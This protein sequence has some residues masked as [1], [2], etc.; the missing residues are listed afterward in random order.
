MD[1]R[2]KRGRHQVY[3]NIGG[4]YS[5][6][7]APAASVGAVDCST[8][9]KDFQRTGEGWYGHTDFV[10]RQPVPPRFSARFDLAQECSYFSK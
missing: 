10:S 4:Y 6:Q 7:E 9:E 3:E 5:D 1:A 2:E 8:A